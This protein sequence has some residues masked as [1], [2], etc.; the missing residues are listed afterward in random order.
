MENEIW[1]DVPNYEGIYQVSSLGRVKSLSREILASNANRISKEK[2]L[3]QHFNRNGY[4]RVTLTK[5]GARKEFKTHQLVAMAFLNHIVCGHD[6]VIDHINEI[7][8]DNKLENL[9]IVSNRLNVSKSQK[10]KSSIY[11]GVSWNKR[12]KKWI[13][14][15]KVKDKLNHLG[16]FNNEEEASQAYNNALINLI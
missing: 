16:Y 9:Q 3:K 15:I 1:K 12:A 14:Y 2:M 10:F 7:K 8:S 5:N 13:S 11:T 4:L 6:L